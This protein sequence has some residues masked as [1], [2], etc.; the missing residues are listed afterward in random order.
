[1]LTEEVTGRSE[2]K[3]KDLVAPMN[4]SN[5]NP[6]MKGAIGKIFSRLWGTDHS[7][8]K[9]QS[10]LDIVD[11]G[12]ASVKEAS[13][14]AFKLPSGPKDIESK[15]ASKDLP[16]KNKSLDRGVAEVDQK[17]QKKSEEEDV[18]ATFKYLSIMTALYL[19]FLLFLWIRRNVLG[20]GSLVRSLFFGH[21][22]RYGVAFLLLPPSVTKSFVPEPMWNFGVRCLHRL[23]KWWKDEKIQAIIPTW[24]HFVLKIVLGINT[25]K[26]TS[27][28]GSQIGNNAG[29]SPPLMALGIF[30]LM[31]FVVH[32]DGLTWIMLG[33]MR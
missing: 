12:F 7:Q 32:P 10:F 17:D 26:N 2:Q 28:L 33:Q 15:E 14:E 29:I 20:T 31:L 5:R 24:V 13:L 3:D 27:S 21:M 18:H 16:L 22:L 11:S 8:R 30:T 9:N 4:T 6:R 1:M 23:E 25:D 19:P